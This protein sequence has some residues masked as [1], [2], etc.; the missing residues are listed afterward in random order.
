M[1][2][3]LLDDAVFDSIYQSA[4]DGEVKVFI[5]CGA[6][7]TSTSVFRAPDGAELYGRKGLMTTAK[8]LVRQETLA[9]VRLAKLLTALSRIDAFVFIQITTGPNGYDWEELDEFRDWI[10]DASDGST[11]PL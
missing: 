1:P 2:D 4:V 9:A 3:T 5:A 11:Q 8:A 6:F 7:S 10:R